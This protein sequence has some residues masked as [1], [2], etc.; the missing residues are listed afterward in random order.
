MILILLYAVAART[1]EIAVR[2]AL[3]AQRRDVAVLVIRHALVVTVGGLALG[4]ATG[5]V[6]TSLLASTLVGVN[7]TDGVAWLLGSATVVLIVFLAAT[8]ATS[9]ALRIAPLLALGRARR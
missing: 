2:V 1:P 3:G 4:V 8:V 6:T 5:A 7:R 9:R